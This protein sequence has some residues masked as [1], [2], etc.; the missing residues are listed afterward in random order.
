MGG[1]DDML[2]YNLEP[3]IYSLYALNIADGFTRNSGKKLKIHLKIETGMHRLGIDSTDLDKPA[4]ILKGNNF[5]EVQSVFSHLVASDD[6]SKDDFTK[7]QVEALDKF[8]D[9][10]EKAIGKNF[11]RHILNSDGISRFPQ[12]Q[13]NMVRLGIG[14]YGL[15][16]K[17]E[18]RKHLKTV[19]TLKSI[20][21][22]IKEVKKG[23]SVGYGRNYVA[24]H[25]I[26]SATIPIGYA[27]GLAREMGN[28]NWSF[29]VNGKPAPIIGNVCM[30]MCMIDI[31]EINN[32]M[33]RDEVFIIGSQ[34]EVYKMAEK[35]NTIPYEILTSFSERVKRIFNYGE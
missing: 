26:K 11:I 16:S 17:E 32:V 6:P 3:E 35:R 21:S 12:Y 20:I 24:D 31:S 29:T 25:D 8:C 15:S 22:Q 4:N 27:D 18:I 34:D 14:L 23:E 13:K 7:S 5:L 9:S 10:L 19:I 28:G 30:D 33:E 1:M 2:E